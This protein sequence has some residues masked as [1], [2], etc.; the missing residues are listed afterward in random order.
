MRTC[1]TAHLAAR[2]GSRGRR[3]RTGRGRRARRRPRHLPRPDSLLYQV[4]ADTGTAR[5]VAVP[6]VDGY[7]GQVAAGGWGATT[8]EA[9]PFHR[10]GARFAAR[11]VPAPTVTGLTVPSVTVTADGTAGPTRTLRLQ[12]T[13]LPGAYALTVDVL[14]PGGVRSV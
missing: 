2:R 8:V 10:A 6:G 13:A 12:T 4:D 5:W 9:D 1:A 14:A 11:S 3:P 7:T